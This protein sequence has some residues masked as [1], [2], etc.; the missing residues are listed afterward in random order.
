[1]AKFIY[2]SY[3]TFSEAE[4]AVEDI[5]HRGV[6]S[7]DVIIAKNSDYV[8]EN[9]STT[10]VEVTS[11][12]TINENESWWEN[13]LDFFSDDRYENPS[14]HYSEYRDLVAEGDVLVLVDEVYLADSSEPG[15]HGTGYVEGYDPEHHAND[16]LDENHHIKLHEE[17]LNVRKEKEN[18]GQVEITKHVVEETKTIEVPVEREEI[19]ITRTNNTDEVADPDA[20]KE[21]TIVVPIS[22]EKVHVNK[23]TVVSGEVDIEKTT[24][25]EQK[26]VSEKVRREIVDVEDDEELIKDDK[27]QY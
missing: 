7:S 8:T 20:F 11:I 25:V 24:E 19:H 14:E 2:G 9:T 23:N 15:Y 17:Q 27:N 12:E 10:G 26:E 18:L 6:A 3:R 13:F 21:E 16:G 5:L 22:E 1:M 4:A